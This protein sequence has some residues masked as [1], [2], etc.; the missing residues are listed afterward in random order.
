MLTKAVIGAVGL[1]AAIGIGGAAYAAT[2]SSPSH[3]TAA[4]AA[5]SVSS[6]AAG[7]S[8]KAKGIY[9]RS[10]HATLEVKQKGQWVTYDLDRGKVTAVSATSI[11]LTRPDGQSVTEAIDANTKFKGVTSAAA[12]QTGRPALVLS[13]NG[14][15]VRIRQVTGTGSAASAGTATAVVGGNLT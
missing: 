15:A 7:G 3:A 2:N 9:A 11:T 10:D 1:A 5:T 14:R 4:T 13:E 12:I 8:G 6:Q